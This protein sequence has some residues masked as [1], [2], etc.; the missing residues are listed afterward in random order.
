MATAAELGT[1]LARAGH[2]V[3]YGGS[4]NGCMGALADAALAA[5][6]S[7]TG[8]TPVH[9]VSAERRHERLTRLEVTADLAAR[10]LRMFELSTAIVVLP[11][12]TGT[13]DEFLEALTMKRLGL[14]PHALVAVDSGGFYAPLRKL[15]RGLV[16]TGFAQ[17]DQLDLIQFVA[18]P[19]DVLPLLGT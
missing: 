7:V 17:Q 6:G 1:L 13:L 5:G 3:I 14:L 16:A 9:P 18:R 2:P 4:A 8:I 15:L 11:G 12:G 10:K 19:A